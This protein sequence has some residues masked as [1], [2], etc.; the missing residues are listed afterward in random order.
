MLLTK[1]TKKQWLLDEMNH[2]ITYYSRVINYIFSLEFIFWKC[3][4]RA[5]VA[6]EKPFKV[7]EGGIRD[8]NSF[9]L[10]ELMFEYIQSCYNVSF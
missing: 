8:N 9:F 10:N 1:V 4:Y 6:C 7:L 3:D 2:H 5:T